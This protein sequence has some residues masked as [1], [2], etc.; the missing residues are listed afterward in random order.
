MTIHWQTIIEYIVGASSTPGNDIVMASVYALSAFF[1]L[2]M[3]SLMTHI[4]Y[5][6]M[7]RKVD[8]GLLKFAGIFIVFGITFIGATVIS[9]IDMIHQFCNLS[10]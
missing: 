8:V 3:A 9:G 1:M 4:E 10:V 6:G 2:I 7:S 5:A